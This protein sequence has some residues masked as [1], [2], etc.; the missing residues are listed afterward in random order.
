METIRQN[1]YVPNQKDII[2][3]HNRS[4]GIMQKQFCVT[5]HKLLIFDFG[6]SRPEREK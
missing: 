6:G 5:N 4:T 2:N 3:I 1:D